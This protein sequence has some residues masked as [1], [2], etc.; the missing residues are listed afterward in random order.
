MIQLDQKFLSLRSALIGRINGK[1]LAL[2][3][4]ALFALQ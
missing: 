2:T 3:K 4:A 1:R